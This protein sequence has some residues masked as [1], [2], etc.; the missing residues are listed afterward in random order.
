M[1]SVLISGEYITLGQ[2]LKM[3]GISQTGGQA[4]FIIMD[5]R[6]KV[7]GQT[8]RQ[9]GRKVFPGDVVEIDKSKRIR[10]NS[11]E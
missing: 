3:S 2:L 8:I 10:V 5:G 6:V 1:E 11:E 4:K 7:N 9:R